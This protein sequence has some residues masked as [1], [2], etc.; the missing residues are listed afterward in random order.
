MHK[1]TNPSKSFAFKTITTTNKNKHSAVRGKNGF[2]IAL[3][4][5]KTIII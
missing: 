2:L 3:Q 5:Q 1:Q 4:K